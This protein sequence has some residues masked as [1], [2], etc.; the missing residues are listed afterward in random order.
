MAESLITICY[1]GAYENEE[2]RTK[3]LV[4]NTS[5]DEGTNQLLDENKT[6]I[7]SLK[8]KGHS[9]TQNFDNYKGPAR[10]SIGFSTNWLNRDFYCG[11]N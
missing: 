5:K 1:E 3:V 4:I 11:N 2:M 8:L 7:Y 10:S 9:R 6:K